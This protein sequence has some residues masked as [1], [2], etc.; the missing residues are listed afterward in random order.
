MVKIG[1]IYRKLVP[2]DFILLKFLVRNLNKFEYIPLD[3]IVKKFRKRYTQKEIVARIKKLT[4]LKLLAKHPTIESYRVTFLGLDCLALNLLVYK[5]V[6]KAIGD[7]IGVGKESEIYRGLG[8]N[9]NLIAIKFYRI[10]R[11]SFRHVAK[12]RGYYENIEQ[13]SWL[14]KSIVAGKREREAL[15]LL[16]KHLVQNVPKIYGGILHTVVIEFIDGLMLYE[17][18]ELSDPYSVFN[19]IIS[20]VKTIYKTVGIVHGDL[21]EYNILVNSSD[22]VEKIYIIDWPQYILVTDPMALQ[23]LERDIKHIVGFFRRR[24]HLDVSL[25]ETFKYVLEDNKS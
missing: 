1:I 12:Y 14:Y 16:N 17:V 5:G 15:F 21:S 19:Q 8:N 13:G 18:K 22:D 24:F 3:I 2:E 4:R 11:Q 23:L 10:G 25:E 6:I 20:T 7:R 9:D